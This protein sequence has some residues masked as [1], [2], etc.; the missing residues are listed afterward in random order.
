MEAHQAP[1]QPGRG[2]HKGH[3]GGGRTAG[4]TQLRQTRPATNERGR[5]HQPNARGNQQR[6]ERCDRIAHPAQH[7]RGQQ[8]HEQAGHGNQDDAGVLRGV[9]QNVGRSA[10][11]TQHGA[12]KAAAEHRHKHTKHHAH[13]E[14]GTGHGTHTVDLACTPG[15]ANQHRGARTQP[16]H[17]GD[18]K[19]HDREETRDRRQRFHAQHLTEVD[20][21]ERAR[22]RLQD[23]ARQHGSEEHR[24]H[25]PKRACARRG[26][27]G[28][29]LRRPHCLHSTTQQPDPANNAKHPQAKVLPTRQSASGRPQTARVRPPR[30]LPVIPPWRS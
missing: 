6:V 4:H 9:L 3:H 5:E 23:V 30:N 21:V 15:L 17:E 8:K 14:R 16:D 22:E 11:R 25:T 24:K 28:R 7:G 10:Q 12:G 2:H 29:L 27:T 1:A 19:E 18:E 13:G 20:V 26:R